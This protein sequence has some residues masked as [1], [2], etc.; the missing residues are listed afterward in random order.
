[1]RPLFAHIQMGS[2]PLYVKSPVSVF[3]WQEAL[4]IFNA[5]AAVALLQVVITLDAKKCDIMQC[6]FT[7]ASHWGV[8]AMRGLLLL[9][10]NPPS[11][12]CYSLVCQRATHDNYQQQLHSGNQ[13]ILKLTWNYKQPTYFLSSGLWDQTRQQKLDFPRFLLLKV[14]MYVAVVI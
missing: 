13:T 2:E 6:F 4:G 10:G 3:L 9:L 12:A 11:I 8:F 1:M 7:P 5:S 14:S